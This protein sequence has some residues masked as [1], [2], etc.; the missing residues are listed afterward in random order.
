MAITDNPDLQTKPARKG[1]PELRKVVSI[2]PGWKA[3]IVDAD[4][5]VLPG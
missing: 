1:L 3:A 2:S 4:P 5:L